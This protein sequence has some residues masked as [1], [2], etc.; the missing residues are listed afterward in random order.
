VCGSSLNDFQT[1]L[2][3]AFVNS[4]VRQALKVL[5]WEGEL[6]VTEVERIQA[7]WFSHRNF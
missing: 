6:S 2:V 7:F 4:L 5:F 3:R 1:L